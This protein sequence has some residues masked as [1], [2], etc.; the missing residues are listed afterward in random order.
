ML[1]EFLFMY[2]LYAIWMF[3]FVNNLFQKYSFLS[4]PECILNDKYPAFTRSDYH[5]WSKC[6]MFFC[7]LILL[8][9]RVIAI[10]GIVIIAFLELKFIVLIFGIKDFNLPQN[11]KFLKISKLCLRIN[12][13]LILLFFGFLWIPKKT[14]KSNTPSYFTKLPESDNAIIVSNHISFIDIFFHLSHSTPVCFVSNQLV[15]NY[16]LV[17]M[18]AQIIQCVFVDRRNKQSRQKCISDLKQ[19]SDKLANNPESNYYFN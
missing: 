17:G 14:I 5:K 11:P 6:K 10:T 18:I 15:I 3:Y 19:R 2:F 7:G 9:I 1:V 13:R 8:P 16:P 12:C 4:K